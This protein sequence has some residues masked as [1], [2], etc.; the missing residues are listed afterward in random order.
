MSVNTE[1]TEQSNESNM[2][3]FVNQ[4]STVKDHSKTP[5]FFITRTKKTKLNITLKLFSTYVNI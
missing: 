1:L 5:T 2:N 3:V 4:L